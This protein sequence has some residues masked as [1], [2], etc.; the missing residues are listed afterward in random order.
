MNADA[1]S[2]VIPLSTLTVLP[3]GAG[4]AGKGGEG[5]DRQIT[6]AE[7]IAAVFPALPTGAFAAVCIKSGDPNVGGWPARRADEVADTLSAAHNNFIGCA[8]PPC[9]QAPWLGSWTCAGQ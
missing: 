2:A 3:T 9:G 8:E 5:G 7:F 4:G 6:N 1:P